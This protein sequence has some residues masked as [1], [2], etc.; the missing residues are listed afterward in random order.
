[1]RENII[2]EQ[3]LS[4]CPVVRQKNEKG[5]PLDENID[6]CFEKIHLSLGQ[7]V[8]YDILKFAAKIE[9]PLILL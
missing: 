1:V 7:P 9:D 5:Q 6:I 8:M 4:E 3:L 2:V